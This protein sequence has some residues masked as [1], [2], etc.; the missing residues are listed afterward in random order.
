MGVGSKNRP[1]R[2]PEQKPGSVELPK[3][4]DKAVEKK[5]RRNSPAP[6]AAAPSSAGG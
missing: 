4:T 5:D 1:R 2:R 3:K 6:P